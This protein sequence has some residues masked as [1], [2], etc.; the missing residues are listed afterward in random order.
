MVVEPADQLR[1]CFI[2]DIEYNDA[3]VDVADVSTIRTFRIGTPFPLRTGSSTA[4]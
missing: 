3:A 4:G 1:M 2:R